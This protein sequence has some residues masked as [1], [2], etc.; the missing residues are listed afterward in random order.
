MI[1]V[2]L[3]ALIHSVIFDPELSTESCIKHVVG[4]LVSPSWEFSKV[5]IVA[6]LAGY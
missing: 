6:A 2:F 5:K 1:F 3:S 4:E